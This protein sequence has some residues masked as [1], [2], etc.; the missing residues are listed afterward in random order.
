MFK[1]PPPRLL[2]A[3]VDS[4]GDGI[5]QLITS[6]SE[7]NASLTSQPSKIQENKTSK[8]EE[9]KN[10]ASPNFTPQLKL[11][12]QTQLRKLRSNSTYERVPELNKTPPRKLWGNSKVTS[13]TVKKS[14]SILSRLASF[15]SPVKKGQSK[16]SP[17]S[18]L[19][20]QVQQKKTPDGNSPELD[21]QTSSRR[22]I[23]EASVSFSNTHESFTRPEPC[24][25]RPQREREGSSVKGIKR[26]EAANRPDTRGQVEGQAS[27][28]PTGSSKS[29][30]RDCP[31]ESTD[32]DSGS[33]EEWF[34]EDNNE[35]RQ[36]ST[37][38]VVED[39]VC[40]V[41]E[42]DRDVTTR[43]NSKDRYPTETQSVARGLAVHLAD[44]TANQG[45]ERRTDLYHSSKRSRGTYP[46]DKEEVGEHSAGPLR[47]HCEHLPLHKETQ[48][49]SR[50]RPPQTRK[51]I[52]HTANY[53]ERPKQHASY[54]DDNPNIF[55]NETTATS[56]TRA[57]IHNQTITDCNTAA[58]SATYNTNSK[59]KT[60]TPQRSTVAAQL[61]TDNLFMERQASDKPSTAGYCP[62]IW[63]PTAPQ[64]QFLA[65]GER[66]YRPTTSNC[67]EPQR[68]TQQE[69]TGRINFPSSNKMAQ[70]DCPPKAATVNDLN[71]FQNNQH[72]FTRLQLLP[73]F[74]GGP[75]TRFDAWLE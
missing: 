31:S 21:V 50:S 73:T 4:Q 36:P 55:R 34:G 67:N 35:E 75:V 20:T 60:T 51:T 58:A 57:E 29:E 56:V 62:T 61:C 25:A 72:T 39:N 23:E 48:E 24:P 66:E 44:P 69:T 9:I 13:E 41:R 7:P 33:E 28:T 65:V 49:N 16:N 1:T 5:D 52:E 42:P 15:I 47:G 26:L 37:N 12:D 64:K 38:R 14:P 10:L 27:G 8:V 70:A 22:N 11:T 53:L 74:N 3:E 32:V 63:E 46:T 54:R 2:I 40:N 18:T 17:P 71:D 19:S 59:Q 68:Q 30:I 45:Q 43:P 6:E